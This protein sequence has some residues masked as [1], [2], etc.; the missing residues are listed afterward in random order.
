MW[1]LFYDTLNTFTKFEVQTP[2]FIRDTLIY[3]KKVKLEVHALLHYN[4]VIIIIL[5]FLKAHASV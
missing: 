3:S 4:T 2:S 5:L 1:K